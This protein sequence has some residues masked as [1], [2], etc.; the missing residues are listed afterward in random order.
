MLFDM[1]PFIRASPI[2]SGEK[3]QEGGGASQTP[4]TLNVIDVKTVEG[5]FTWLHS[6]S[7]RNFTGMFFSNFGLLYLI[8]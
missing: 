7:N 8:F 5:T 1:M 6:F 3:V 4:A 2:E